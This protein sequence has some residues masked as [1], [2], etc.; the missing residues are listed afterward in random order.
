MKDLNRE[1][2]VEIAGHSYRLAFGRT[3][4][5]IDIE[6]RKGQFSQNQYAHMIGTATATGNYASFI[7]DAFATFSVLAPEMAKN[8]N[9]K[10]FFDLDLTDTQKIV[11]VYVTKV[12]PWINEWMRF[13]NKQV[14]E[15]EKTAVNNQESKDSE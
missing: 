11:E 9:K 3:G 5:L 2:V 8:L 12:L 6:V 1:L 10:S 7:V 15:V 4:D 14:E 13:L